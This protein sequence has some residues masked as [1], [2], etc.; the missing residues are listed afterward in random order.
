MIKKTLPHRAKVVIIGGGIIG[1]SIAYH[2][3]KSGVSGVV[4]IERNQLTSGTT[5]HAA[6]L[7]SMLWP[8]ATLTNLAEYSHNLYASLEAET[9]QATGYKRIGSLSLARNSERMEELQRTCSLAKVFNVKSEMIG[10]SRIEKLYPGINTQGILGA[11]YIEKDGQTNPIDTTIALAKG[12]RMYGATII[13]NVKVDEFIVSDGVV[14]GVITDNGNIMADKVVLCSGMW[15]RDMAKT[16]GVSLPLYACEHFYVVTE[17]MKGLSSRPVLRDFDNGIYLKEDAGKMLVGWFEDNAKGLSMSKINDDFSFGHLPFDMEH[18]ERHLIKAMEL[19]PQFGSV[20][21]RTWFNGPESFTNDNLHLLGPVAEVANLFV[22]C[23]M[24]SRGIGAGGGVGKIMAHWIIN[25]YP[26]DDIYACDVLRNHARQTSNKYIST[27]IPEVL[28]HTYAMHWP[29]YQYTTARNIECSPLHSILKTKGACFGDVC[30]YER[31][32]WFANKGQKA[33]YDYSYKRQQWF[34]NSASEHLAVRNNVGVYD[35]SSFGKFE[36]SGKDALKNLQY[37]AAGNIDIAVGRIVYTHFLNDRG[38]IEADITIVRLQEQKYWI[39]TG[40]AS[41]NRDWWYLKRNLRGEVVLKDISLDYGC[42]AIQG[43]NARKVLTKI[44]NTDVSNNGFKFASG[45]SAI[46]ACVK[47]WMQRISYVGELGW[48]IFIHKDHCEA[49]YKT[50]ITA[51]AE[52]AISN[53]G[54]HAVNS[55]RLEKGYRHWGHDI[56]PEDCLFTSGLSWAAKPEVSDFIG[57][58]AFLQQ[59]DKIFKKRLVQFKLDNFEPLLYHNETIIMDGNIVGYLSSGAYGHFVGSSVGM[60]YVKVPNLTND[61]IAN[62]NFEI[63][64][65]LKTYSAKASLRGF[66]DPQGKNMRF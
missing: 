40:I 17:E 12:A 39:I 46:V 25:G 32:N 38:G 13:E 51:G 57:K 8:S 54:L 37:I 43:P 29:F 14:K 61:M 20:G 33:E 60:G 65:A 48:E 10:N 11:L 52:F 19:F 24:N 36:I 44:T 16:I 42:I 15:S 9:K 66:Y 55:L 18:S 3:A 4:L 28:G 34:A 53:I 50:I 26:A 30:G 45:C 63:E 58:K 64:I 5:W 47:V 21:I 59:Q 7:V 35:M 22:A 56:C 41:I 1:C 27:R 6:G 31:P 49:V 62:A 23:G 2:L